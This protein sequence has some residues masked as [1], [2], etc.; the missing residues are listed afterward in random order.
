MIIQRKLKDGR[1]YIIRS[2]AVDDAAS[3]IDYLN[4]IAGESDNLTFGAG[5]LTITEAIEITI[6][7]EALASTTDLFLVAECDGEIIGNLKFGNN[8]RKRLE[9]YGEFGIS[10]LA[11]CWGNGIGT[12]LLNY[13]IA[14]AKENP[15]ITKI[16]LSVRED[17][18]HGISIYSKLGFVQEGLITR[19][20]KIDG[21][22]YSAYAMGLI[23]D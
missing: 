19:S 13:L 6:I 1:E 23:V 2:I 5:E 3:M 12:E 22:Y 8:R 4:E 20:F 11:A 14:W 15:V 21:K 17:N 18:L 9:H 16:N 7:E 10:V